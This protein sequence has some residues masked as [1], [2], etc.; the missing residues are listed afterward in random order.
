[1]DDNIVK[2]DY[3]N[4]SSVVYKKEK[5]KIVQGLQLSGGIISWLNYKWIGLYHNHL[6]VVDNGKRMGYIDRLGHE[7]IELSFEVAD[8]FAEERAFATRDFMTFLLDSNEKIVKSWDEILV[9]GEFK[10]GRA[11]ISR[12][13]DDAKS[14]EHGIIDKFGNIIVEFTNS[15]VIRDIEEIQAEKMKSFWHEGILRF[16]INGKY[17]VRDTLG[18]ELVSD[19]E[20]Y[21]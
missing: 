5:G 15:R 16:T 19:Y 2:G 1:M 12:I 14:I 9:T 4:G 18:N 11:L 3:I 20:I 13:V 7:V 8:D 6:A 21:F 10:N 17:G